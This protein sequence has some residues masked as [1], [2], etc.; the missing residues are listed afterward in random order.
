MDD[1]GGMR[2]LREIVADVAQD[3]QRIVRG[4]LALARVEL[5][6]KLRQIVVALIWVV[7]GMF[8]GFAGLIVLLTALVDALAHVMPVWAAS[9]IVGLVIIA[10]AGGLAFAGLRMLSL[11][12]LT[13]ERVTRNVRQDARLVKEHI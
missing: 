1:L 3:A 13:P 11:S 7:G 4:E 5:D 2:T 9:I 8:V 10:I 12:N 6:R